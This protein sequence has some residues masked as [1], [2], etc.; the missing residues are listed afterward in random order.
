MRVIACQYD[1]A[2]ENKQLNFETVRT[3][4]EAD[5]PP[6]GSLVVL[7]EMFAT[8]F[9]MN[10]DA[11]AEPQAGPTER[12][13]SGLALTYRAFVTA[14]LVLRGRDGRDRN[15]AAV[16]GP[17]GALILRYVKRY[18]F[19][20]GGEDGHYRAGAEP[21]V[22]T[23]QS[24]PV[25]VTICYDLRF[26]EWYRRQQD[27]GVEMYLVLAN[28][29]DPRAEHWRTLL[30]ARAIENQAYVVGVNRVGRDPAHAYAGDS[31][32]I[33]PHGKVLA[34]AGAGVGLIGAEADPAALRSYRRRFPV[35]RDRQPVVSAAPSSSSVPA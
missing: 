6:P 15:C 23:W 16:F 22:F 19:A 4:L 28:W 35:L 10:A 31:L 30:C 12:F 21:A 20:P 24:M 17:D 25:A 7:P 14:G 18:P 34:D 2:W 13:L 32:I 5:A 26:P 33:D 8:G 29:P 1:I 11:I 9:S 3:L 27:A